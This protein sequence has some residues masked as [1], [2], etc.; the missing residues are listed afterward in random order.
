LPSLM[1]AV[2][3]L[4]SY[5]ILML[6]RIVTVDVLPFPMG[7]RPL[8]PLWMALFNLFVFTH[9]TFLGFLMIAMTKERREAEQRQYALLDPLTGLLNRRAFMGQVERNRRRPRLGRT[10]TVVLVL[11]LDHFKSVND[12][13]G[14]EVGDRVLK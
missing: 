12:R 9:V 10:P 11:D 13:F 2:A 4:V 14:H 6:L 1:P 7:G 5:G 8:D 3:T